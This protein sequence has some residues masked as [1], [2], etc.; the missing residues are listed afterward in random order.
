VKVLD[1]GVAKL[2]QADA[3]M[4][5]ATGMLLGPLTPDYASP[6]QIRGAAVTTTCDVY[7]LGVMLYEL[8]SGHRPYNTA[9]KP[10]DEM[11]AVV[12]TAPPARPSTAQP[13][14]V[15]YHPRGL[16]GDLDAIVLRALEKDPERR[17]ASPEELAEELQRYLD[18]RAVVARAPSLLYVASR[19]IA[20]HK[21]AFA[22]ASVLV[23]LLLATV[24]EALRQARVAA[25]E[26]ERA[27]RR[28]AQTQ[29]LAH[30]VIFKIHDAIVG[31][32]GTIRARQMIVDEARAYLQDLAEDP[33]AA[34]DVRIKLAEA[35]RELGTIQG[36]PGLANLGDAPGAIASFEHGLAL[37]AP[38]VARPDTPLAA[39]Y[40]G[41][42]LWARL[43][44]TLASLPGQRRDA[45][46]AARRSLEVATRMIATEPGSDRTLRALADANIM[47]AYSVAP[48]EAAPYWR[49]ALDQHTRLLDKL[50]S[51]P[52]RMVMVALMETSLAAHLEAHLDGAGARPHHRGAKVLY[53]RLLAAQRIHQCE[54]C[55]AMVLGNAG[56]AGIQLGELKDARRMLQ[57]ALTVLLRI[58][59]ADHANAN[60]LPKT[61]LSYGQL[62]RAEEA[63]GDERA[64]LRHARSA[65]EL[66]TRQPPEPKLFSILVESQLR[67]GRLALRAGRGGE[68]CPALERA[69]ATFAK[70]A[71]NGALLPLERKL[72][73][74]ASGLRAQCHHEVGKREQS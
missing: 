9:G 47:L 66:F 12:L 71:A 60:A 41:S 5:Q 23:L 61:A 46:Q 20:R 48:Q 57:Q 3:P 1:F 4:A 44:H 33:G 74:E 7:A 18:G 37:L 50:P 17:Y 35:N 67:V 70:M 40:E 30:A 56:V 51:D 11:L 36:Y 52:E 10:I 2:L 15:P 22:V 34:D 25:R 31:L 64:A 43:S 27:E 53:E 14:E 54:E 59:E 29:A 8:I 39:L 58:A 63:L 6:E 26:R 13:G 55:Y 65:V 73:D 62:A 49:A 16:R 28:F 69:T 38:M 19:T 68:A 24:A 72:A 42:T 32:P 45:E 21:R